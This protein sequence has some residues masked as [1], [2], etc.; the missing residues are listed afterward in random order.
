MAGPLVRAPGA[1]VRLLYERGILSERRPAVQEHRLQVAI[2]HDQ[3]RPT[4]TN[5]LPPL[6]LSCHTRAHHHTAATPHHT[7]PPLHTTHPLQ[8]RRVRGSGDGRRTILIYPQACRG[9]GRRKEAKLGAARQGKRSANIDDKNE[10]KIALL[11]SRLPCSPLL[12][13]LLSRAP[14]LSSPPPSATPPLL[15]SALGHP[16]VPRPTHR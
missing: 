10:R 13:P 7:P 5:L 15:S 3:P 12:S 6:P 11:S 16:H 14:L 4:T 9:I 1:R 8:P 2:N